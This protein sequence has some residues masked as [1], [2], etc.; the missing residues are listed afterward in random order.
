MRARA[1]RLG[2][3]ALGLAAVSLTGEIAVTG[4]LGR[5]ATIAREDGRDPLEA[6]GE[7]ARLRAPAGG[8]TPPP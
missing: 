4:G 2:L 6:S 1:G 5:L 7:L 3:L 8:Y